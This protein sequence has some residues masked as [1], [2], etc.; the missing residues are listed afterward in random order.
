MSPP[1]AR[2]DCR[3]FQVGIL[4]R[5][6]VREQALRGSIEVEL[7]ERNRDFGSLAVLVE[8][9]RL[10]R[11][12]PCGERHDR[13]NRHGDRYRQNVEDPRAGHV[14][15]RV[16]EREIV[17][18]QTSWRSFAREVETLTFQRFSALDPRFV[19]RG[20]CG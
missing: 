17:E 8:D 9:G 11:S 2:G 1:S 12:R 7:E 15:L 3:G 18:C 16:G 14:I 4:E 13:A 19:T 5:R 10:Q 20:T 6:R